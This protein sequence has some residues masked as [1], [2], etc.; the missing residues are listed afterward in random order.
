MESLRADRFA[1]PHFIKGAP[2]NPSGVSLK[3]SPWDTIGNPLAESAP[4]T[5][6]ILVNLTFTVTDSTDDG[7]PAVTSRTTEYLV[8]SGEAISYPAFPPYDS[9]C[10]ASLPGNG[11]EAP[12]SSRYPAGK[13]PIPA[14]GQILLECIIRKDREIVAT[15]ALM[16]VDGEPA[17]VDFE[18]TEHAVHYILDV[19][20]TSSKEKIAAAQ[21]AAAERAA[22]RQLQ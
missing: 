9:T 2:P 4:E 11:N 16:A 5:V 19:A 3:P 1:I 6:L 17:K 10:K 14:A 22:S 8:N 13:G 15:P 21:A 20:A 18:S 7:L 12:A